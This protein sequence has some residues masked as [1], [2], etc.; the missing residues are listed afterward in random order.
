MRPLYFDCSPRMAESLTAPLRA[1]CPELEIHLGSVPRAELPAQLAG[2]SILVLGNTWLGAEEL[3]RLPALRHIVFLGTGA[4][5]YVDLAAAQEHG[6]AV[7]VIPGYGNRAV[8]EHTLALILACARQVATMDRAIRA[9]GF[10]SLP[11]M[12]LGGKTLGLVGLG[13]IGREVARLGDALGMRVIAWTRSGDARGAPVEPC[14][15]DDVFARADV[16]S[17][18]VALTDATRGIVDAR[19]LAAMKP[20]SLLINTA[21]GAIVDEA[22]LVEALRRGTPAAAGID[23]FSDEPPPADHPLRALENVVLTGHAAFRT[24]EASQR[25]IERA[26]AIVNQLLG[27]E[28]QL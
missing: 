17:L 4:A 14:A 22:A 15:L 6:V 3:A 13:D 18:H 20:G 23:V 2:R 11:G 9:G 8:A 10:P 12:E 5:S 26:L 7:H 25:L 1:L 24:P 16:V 19:R 28:R 27:S 21:R